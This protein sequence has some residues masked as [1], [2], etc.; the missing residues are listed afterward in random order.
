MR[1]AEGGVIYQESQPFLPQDSMMTSLGI[2]KV[3]DGL[4]QQ[5]GLVG[6][7]YPTRGM[8]D[9]GASASVYPALVNP[10]VTFN[11]FAGSLGIDDGTPRNIYTLDT[12]GMTQLTGADTG[13]SGIELRP[14]SPP[15]FRT[16]GAR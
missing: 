10:V 14:G 6:F 5:V 1:N 8:L 3:P 16:A 12:S 13:V 2:V 15:T 9:T 11:V 7:F 4:P